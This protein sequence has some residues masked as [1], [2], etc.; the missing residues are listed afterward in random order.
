[1]IRLVIVEDHAPA[2]Q[3]VLQELSGTDFIEVVAEAETSDEA[4]RLAQKLLPDVVLLDL[5]LPGLL[6]Q[7]VLLKKLSALKN[8]R[9]VIFADAGRAAQVQELL[10]AGARAY[11]LKQ[12]PGELLRMSILMV[13]R[14][15][16]RIVSP[17]LPKNLLRLTGQERQVLSEIGKRG[18][19]V[20][21]AQRMG[22]SEADLNQVISEIAAKLEI[23]SNEKLARW[24]KKN[25]F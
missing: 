10:D 18:G 21:A 13:Y 2:R 3:K 14:G 22:L 4:L 25:G 7:P 8:V 23:E 9:V 24:A 5:H 19:I 12:D 1:M 20:R 16:R 11:V 17:G 6:A 15:S